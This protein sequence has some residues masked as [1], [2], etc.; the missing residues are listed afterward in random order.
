MHHDEVIFFI[1]HIKKSLDYLVERMDTRAA[2]KVSPLPNEILGA[3]QVDLDI[4]KDKIMIDNQTY[5]AIRTPLTL[6]H[7]NKEQK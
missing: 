3:I 1:E 4:L 6:T 5:S 7:S 2:Y